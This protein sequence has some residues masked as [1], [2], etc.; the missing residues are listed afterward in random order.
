MSEDKK[1]EILALINR[2]WDNY[3]DKM[4][5]ARDLE[6]QYIFGPLGENE[7][8]M[9]DDILTLIKEVELEKNPLPEPVVVEEEP[10]V[11]VEEEPLEEIIEE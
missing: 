11:V 8:Y 7:H 9:I 2:E 1:I 6:E 3:E 5:L 10:V 4:S